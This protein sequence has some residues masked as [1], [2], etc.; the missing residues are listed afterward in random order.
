MKKLSLQ[1]KI[2]LLVGIITAAAC[3]GVT[4]NS[5][6]SA[7]VYY[8]Q[9]LEEGLAEVDSV[10]GPD[11]GAYLPDGENQTVSDLPA[12]YRDLTRLFSVQ[13]LLVMVAIVAVSLGVTYF[14]TGRVL[15]PLK[16]L[17][18]S[19]KEI[20]GENLH[21]R[22]ELPKGEDEV[23]ELTGS[24][25]AMLGRLE[26]AFLVQKNFAAN[27]AHELKTPLAVMKTSLQVLELDEEPSPEDYQEFR[28]DV[29][30]GLER[31]TGTVDNLLA[32]ANDSVENLE[33]VELRE[34][35]DQAGKALRERAKEKGIAVSVEG[36]APPVLGNRILL[37]RVFFNLMENAVKYNREGGE[38]RAELSEQD[39]GAWVE[40]SDTGMG[41]PAESLHH[42]FE[43]F[44]RAD[45]SRSQRI[46][47]AG[48]GLSIVRTVLDRC[49]GTIKV[50]SVE[51][52]GTAIR[53]FLPKAES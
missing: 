44:Y 16:E 40:I 12:Y 26:D 48:L 28:E 22:V 33:P 46:P 18:R 6:F 2:T 52:K 30:A 37:Y 31:L 5:V 9:I 34:L 14:V 25:N 39:G 41:I 36:K 35:V 11:G 10:L 32:L 8:A 29:A 13:S 53:V 51:G 45:R 15:R 50:D 4:L 49:G 19:V 43:P 23:R 21:R 20:G 24:F 42:I 47:G 17:N 38:V 1:W 3:L 7:P 27:A